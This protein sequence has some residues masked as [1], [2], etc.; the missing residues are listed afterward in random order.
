LNEV[1]EAMDRAEEAARFL[2]EK[3][4]NC[5]QAVLCA[6]CEDFGLEK[7]LALGLS[8]GFGGGIAHG[9]NLCG[10]VTGAYLA[11]GLAL[12]ATIDAPRLNIESTYA[13]MHEFDRRFIELHGT[14]RCTELLGHDLSKPEVLAKAKAENIF[15]SRCPSFVRDAVKIVEALLGA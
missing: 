4:S 2:V 9:D 1:S 5:S 12:P 6:F 11:L 3:R 7:R 13:L 14:L 10:A 15:V 8:Q